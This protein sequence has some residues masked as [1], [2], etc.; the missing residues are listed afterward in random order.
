MQ[1]EVI[2]LRLR[3]LPA[4][5]NSLDPSPFHEKDLDPAAR[6]YIVGRA[7]D[8]PHDAPLTL[9]V[10]LDRRPAEG[11]VA[12]LVRE[13]VHNDF[14]YQAEQRRRELR[15]LLAVGRTSLLIGIL[16]LGGCISAARLL[17]PLASNAF[18]RVFSE[19]VIIGG[20]VAMWRPI[21]IF[22]YDWWPLARRLRL[23]R[24][25]AT[26]EVRMAAA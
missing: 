18:V 16:F 1:N 19:S 5:F 14:A 20:W 9:V 25:L 11:D 2:E 17:E 8:L 10:H 22:L 24:R 7:L 13:A 3:E 6:E 12:A 4:L 21:E 23:L 15:S 26:C